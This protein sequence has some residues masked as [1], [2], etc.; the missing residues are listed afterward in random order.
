[1][2]FKGTDEVSY[3][4]LVFACRFL[5]PGTASWPLRTRCW[6]PAP[7]AAARMLLAS[8]LTRLPPGS[9]LAVSLPSALLLSTCC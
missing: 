9:L 1:M 6:H 7:R 2:D 5:S 8:L 3:L 4:F